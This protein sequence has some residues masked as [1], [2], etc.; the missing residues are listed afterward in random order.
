MARRTILTPAQRTALLALPTDRAELA[1]HCTLSEAELAVIGRRRRARN[2]LGFALQLCALRYPGR[3]LRPGELVPTPIVAFVAEQ[4]GV[5]PATLADYA[6]RENSPE[7]HVA[8]ELRVRG[9]R[10]AVRRRRQRLEGLVVPGVGRPALPAHLAGFERAERARRVHHRTP[11]IAA[12][13]RAA[14]ARVRP[15]R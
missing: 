6:F 12:R 5:D 10:L 3:L 9:R 13:R 8:A 11:S 15:N 4:I 7:L 2:R 14:S 1:R